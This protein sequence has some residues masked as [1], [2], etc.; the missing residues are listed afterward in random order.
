MH[1]NSGTIYKY[2]KN[3]AIMM[4]QAKDALYKSEL[5]WATQFEIA[6]KNITDIIYDK[7]CNAVA[8]GNTS[9]EAIVTISSDDIIADITKYL[10]YYGY[11][12]TIQIVSFGNKNK[13]NNKQVNV[14]INWGA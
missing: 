2:T 13:S 1:F 9:V 5:N 3:K 8:H 10:S 12:S 4:I 6:N 7:I 14:Y 11:H